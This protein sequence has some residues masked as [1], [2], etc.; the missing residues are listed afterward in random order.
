MRLNTTGLGIGTS[1][2]SY[3]L[4]VSGTARVTGVF[5]MSATGGFIVNSGASTSSKYI[6]IENTS[7]SLFAGVSSS[8]GTGIMSSGRA[9]SAAL[10]GQAGIQFSGNNGTTVHMDLDTSGNLGLGVTP[11]AWSTN[12]TAIEL[13]YASGGSVFAGLYPIIAANAY[14]DATDWKYGTTAAASYYSQV[15]GQHRWYNAPSGTAGNAITFTQAMTLDAS[16]NLLIAKTA[17]D[18]TATG[19][20]YVKSANILRSTASGGTALQLNRIT[21][22][23]ELASFYNATSQ[24]GSI[25]VSSVLT[26]YNTTSDYRLKTVVGS[27][28]GHGARIDAL[29]PI[30]YIWNSNGSRTRGFLAHKFQEVYADSVTGTKDAV[31][32]NG[33]PIYQQMQASSSEVIADIVAELK[34]LRKRL[35]DAGIA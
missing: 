30:E 12:F 25:S 35:A 34:S 5:T 6:D 15:I 33:K 14:R 31:D 28:I 17:S 10:A 13:K 26:T 16:G 3:K 8:S 29:E 20:E 9:Y 4:D 21:S 24:V 7:G 19:F 23:G 27:V 11:S 2:P 18:F 1:S 22:T 32:A